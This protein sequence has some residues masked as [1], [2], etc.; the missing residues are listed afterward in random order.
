MDLM[1]V[2]MQNNGFN[3]DGSALTTE[4]HHFFLISTI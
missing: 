2:C 3:A 1:N 4:H